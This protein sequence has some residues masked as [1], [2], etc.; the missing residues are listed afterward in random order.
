MTLYHDSKQKLR[1]VCRTISVLLDGD[2]P[3][4]SGQKA[5]V[6]LRGIF[7]DLEGKLDRAH[8][9]ADSLTEAR[10]SSLVN[11]KVYQTLPILGFILRST[12]VRNAFEL[13]DPLQSV[14][15][16]VLQGRPQLLL[17]SEWEYVPF[18]YPQSLDDLKSFVLIGLPASEAASALLLPLAGHELGHA[19][20]RNRGIGGGVH[21]TLQLKCEDSYNGQMTEFKRQFPEYDET[22]FVNKEILPEAIALSVEYA[23]FQ[24]EELFCDMFAYALFGES[25]LYA[26]AYILAPGSGRLPGSRYPSHKARIETLIGIATREGSLLP[27]FASLG[28]SEDR[29]RGSGTPRDRFILRICEDSVK[30]ITGSLWDSVCSL[31]IE[32]KIVRPNATMARKHLHEFKLGIP[33][34]QPRSLG[35]IINA[36]WMYYREVQ[37]ERDAS[38][39]LPERFDDLNEILLKTIEV[40]EFNQRTQHGSKREET[41]RGNRTRK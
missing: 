23:V 11:L 21:T 26:F 15:D 41:S 9:L 28:F 38:K 7:T 18:A 27:D 20:W 25:Y 19:A 31:A 34:H 5:L 2:F 40:L 17:S 12:N 1:N 39:S 33:A 32:G 35:D 6:K 24:A 37:S 8:N 13:L 14:A 10:L 30:A 36:G 22:D 3:L 29:T 16:S 4:S